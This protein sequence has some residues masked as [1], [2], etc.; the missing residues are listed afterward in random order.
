[1]KIFKKIGL[2]LLVIGIIG[3]GSYIIWD[4]V[5][6]DNWFQKIK[7]VAEET[8]DSGITGEEYT[9]FDRNYYPYYGFLSKEGRK[10]Y[11][12][13]YANALAKESKF[14]P[15]VKITV[16][17]V[18]NVIKAVFH[19]HPEL[20]WMDGGFGYKF[21]EDKICT[22]ITLQFN[23]IIH[24]IESA[25]KEFHKKANE[26]IEYASQM[27]DDYSKE[28]HVYH[29]ILQIAEYDEDA[30]LNQSPYS[31]LVNGKSVCAGYARA[32]QYIM[33]ELG[34]PTYY[35]TG[36]SEGHAWNIVKLEDGYYNVDLTWDDERGTEMTYFNRTDASLG[37][38]HNRS[39]YSV[40]LPKCTATKYV[41]DK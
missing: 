41:K 34:I 17:E 40:L 18:E 5:L 20:F 23:D 25:E 38:S 8:R 11:G 4:F 1:M 9:E 31:A 19:D 22:H 16:S 28:Y 15:I 2:V 24:D 30:E 33:I 21:S 3:I 27:G 36:K 35:C 13:V 14:V 10:L 12:Q 7:Q 26:I 39:G 29:K 6:P 32:F 37:R